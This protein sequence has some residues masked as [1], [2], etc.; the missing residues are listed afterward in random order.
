MFV[1]KKSLLITNTLRIN[2]CVDKGSHLSWR[3][4]EKH[5]KFVISRLS[6]FIWCDPN[7]RAYLYDGKVLKIIVVW[8]ALIC[9][10]LVAGDMLAEFYSERSRVKS[11]WKQSFC[12]NHAEPLLHL[13]KY[14][15]A[16]KK[17]K[18]HRALSEKIGRRLNTHYCDRGLSLG[19]GISTRIFWQIAD[20]FNQQPLQSVR[21]SSLF[22]EVIIMLM[23]PG[24]NKIHCLSEQHQIK[25]PHTYTLLQMLSSQFGYPTNVGKG[26][27]PIHT[28]R[29]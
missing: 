24:N 11:N 20:G 6:I 5:E 28:I 16:A 27:P 18:G 29:K 19:L 3:R 13:H 4:K 21:V 15:R 8:R 17:E 25:F 26:L 14:I 12:S 2:W 22:A 7:G 23:E 1:R 9:L 10:W